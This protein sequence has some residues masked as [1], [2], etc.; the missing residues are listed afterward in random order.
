MAFT[1][2]DLA[3]YLQQHNLGENAKSYILE[4]SRDLARNVGEGSYTRIVTQYQSRKMGTSINTE[5]RTGE[6]AYGI[7]LDFDDDVVAL[8][9]QP[10]TVACVRTY[11]SGKQIHGSYTPDYLVLHKNGPKVIQIKAEDALLKLCEK[12]PDWRLEDGIYR[13]CAAEHALSKYNL[14]HIV[15]SS[16]SLGAQNV[17]NV[18]LLLRSLSH[19]DSQ[20]EIIYRECQNVLKHTGAKSLY[21]IAKLL[22]L[23]D[24]TPILRLIACGRLFT[25]LDECALTE[26]KACFITNDKLLAKKSIIEHW[27]ELSQNHGHTISRSCPVNILPSGADLKKGLA[28]LQRLDSGEKGRSINRWKKRIREGD[29]LGLSAI[30]CVTPNNNKKGNRKRKRPDIVLNFAE[31]FVRTNWRADIMLTASSL[32][33]IYKYEAEMLHPE[34]KHISRPSFYNILKNIKHTLAFQ[35]GGNRLANAAESPTDIS[36]RA[37]KPSRPFELASCDHYLADIYCIVTDANNLTYAIRP[38]IT[39]LRDV[40]TKSVLA[41]SITYSHPSRRSCALVIRQCVRNHGRLP[42]TI[43]VDNGSEFQSVYFSALLSHYGV[44]L[45]FRPSGHPRYGSEA[46]RFFGQFKEL[47]LSCRPGNTVSVKEIRSVSGSH[48]PEKQAVLKIEDLWGDLLTFNKWLD[49]YVTDS[50]LSS[51]LTLQTEGLLRYSCSGLIIMYDDTFMIATAVDDGKYTVSAQRGL[52]IGA[53][54]FWDPKLATLKPRTSVDVRKDPENPYCVYALIQGVWTACHASDFRSFITKDPLAQAAI[55][56]LMLSGENIRE[57]IKSDA[58]RNLIS[59]V[60]SCEA[61]TL[62]KSM[63]STMVKPESSSK[64]SHRAVNDLF[65]SAAGANL[66]SLEKSKW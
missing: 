46:E 2:N 16:A 17:S 10:P 15:I 32:F 28:N 19:N 41:L 39:V 62:N 25:D 9:E 37:S 7:L 23:E 45:M 56:A 51:P 6:L 54:H 20:D 58:D 42:E 60:K 21:E 52:H 5:S 30:A 66:E 65:S 59:A 33:R 35:R 3:I 18:R 14:P 34:I 49:G 50:S 38:W 47:W 29:I 43:V 57:A 44:N 36:K 64:I 55:G 40:F 8:Y 31:D 27:N 53:L 13:D 12:S 26:P 48:R 61:R 22:E 11:N 4:A 63:F 1:S 24:Y